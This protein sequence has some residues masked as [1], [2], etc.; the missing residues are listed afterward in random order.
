MTLR[1]VGMG[2]IKG[3]AAADAEG[4]LAP[5]KPAVVPPRFVPLRAG[6][7]YP[8]GVLGPSVAAIG[9]PLGGATAIG[10]AIIAPYV[11]PAAPGALPTGGAATPLPPP[12]SVPNSPLV[13]SGIRDPQ[14]A[15]VALSTF[16]DANDTREKFIQRAMASY[17]GT[18]TFS[19][20]VPTITLDVP[21]ALLSFIV[22]STNWVADS[23]QI[24]CSSQA[25]LG[26]FKVQVDLD[27]NIQ[28]GPTYLLEGKAPLNIFART[29][30]TINVSIIVPTG[31]D[32]VAG[33]R[34]VLN[35]YRDVASA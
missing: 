19:V 17:W 2:E 24:V 3:L 20:A 6:S 5:L 35:G 14:Q 12:A 9:T 11:A 18:T 28:W 34:V 29:G 4:A 21:S 15:Q 13:Y 32:F 26:L 25:L 23:F 10:E 27:G 1:G 8:R 31:I 30:Q 22:K 7:M 33:A 16:S